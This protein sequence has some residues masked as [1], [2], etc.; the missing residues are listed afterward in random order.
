MAKP[1]PSPRPPLSVVREGNPGHRPVPEGVKTP[2]AAPG[3]LEPPDWRELFP[4]FRAPSRPRKP[5]GRNAT[6]EVKL[7][8]YEEK[9]GMWHRMR[10][11][12]EGSDRCRARA[13]AE[14]AR[15]V[16]VLVKTVGLGVID[17]S[18]VVDYCV[19]RARLD[20]CELQLSRDGLVVMGQRGLC[21]NPLTTVASQYRAAMKHHTG[22]LGLSPSSRGTMQP[23]GGDDDDDVFD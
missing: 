1:G 17:Y 15:I 18:L 14:W 6:D 5:T 20:W 3:E 2:P 8:A 23:P 19:T 21:R 22:E 12:K 9:L 4:A 16:P 13:A 11:A 7:E 10:L